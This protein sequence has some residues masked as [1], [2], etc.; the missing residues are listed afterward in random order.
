M[1]HFNTYVLEPP[2]LSFDVAHRPVDDDICSE[3]G[4]QAQSAISNANVVKPSLDWFII[5]V[6]TGQDLQ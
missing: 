4:A 3:F 1:V 6:D 2:R 5:S